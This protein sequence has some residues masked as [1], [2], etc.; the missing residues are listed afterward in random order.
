MRAGLDR[1][2]GEVGGVARVV[3]AGAGDDRRLV[4]QLRDH[5]PARPTLLVVAQRRRLARRAA[6]HEAVRAV[7]EQVPAERDAASSLTQ[8]SAANGVTIA[9]RRPAGGTHRL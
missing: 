7:G 3:G 6:D 8:P 4:A 2:L 5:Q 9:V 1:G